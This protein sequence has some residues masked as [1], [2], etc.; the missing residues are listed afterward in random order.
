VG[1][2]AARAVLEVVPDDVMR[3]GIFQGH[4]AEE[5]LAVVDA[6]SLDAAQLHGEV[7]AAL[8]EELS[9]RGVTVITAVSL[10]GSSPSGLEASAAD[11]VMLDAPV[12]GGGVPF[13]WELVGDLV[14]RHTVL[15]AGGLHPDNVAEAIRV[16]RPWGVDVAS[17][18]EVRPGQ[19]DPDAIAAFVAAARGAA[20]PES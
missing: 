9:E 20:R 11:V 18:V 14:D 13:D 6:L 1:L 17:G 10:V 7:S 8:V 2:E 4:E 16:V 19:K 12:A 3:A 15:L 5:V